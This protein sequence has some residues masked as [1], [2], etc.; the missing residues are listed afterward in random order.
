MVAITFFNVKRSL[1]IIE[2]VLLKSG[3]FQHVSIGE[4][5]APPKAKISAHVWMERT[6]VPITFLDAPRE[7]HELC[8]RIYK[9]MIAIPEE[10]I[11]LELAEATSN[12]VNYLYQ[13]ISLGDTV[14]DIDVGGIHGKPLTTDWGHVRVAAVLYRCVDI[15]FSLIVDETSQFEA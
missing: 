11:E 9:E 15:K 10:T 12:A 8:V 3:Y 7:I 14:V 13:N 1:E 6:S 4:P 2:N 5:K